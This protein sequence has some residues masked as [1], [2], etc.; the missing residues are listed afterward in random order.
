MF[1]QQGVNATLARS[2]SSCHSTGEPRAPKGL[3]SPAGTNQHKPIHGLARVH[4]HCFAR[5][6]LG[7]VWKALPA[8][9]APRY[10]K[11]PWL[12]SSAP[13]PWSIIIVFTTGL[14]KAQIKPGACLAAGGWCWGRV[15]AGRGRAEGRSLTLGSAAGRS[16]RC[17]G[18]AAGARCR[19]ERGVLYRVSGKKESPWKWSKNLFQREWSDSIRAGL[20]GCLYLSSLKEIAHTAPLLRV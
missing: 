17:S 2:P 13:H 4:P 20:Y 12:C 6:A 5:Q 9:P 18:P 10:S 19:R 14:V 7:F 1:P 11:V 8:A 3:L 16:G 15:R